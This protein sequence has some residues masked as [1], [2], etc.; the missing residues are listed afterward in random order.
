M[1]AVRIHAFGGP[2]TLKV[3]DLPKPEAQATEVLIRILGASVNPVDYK[4]RK[5]GYLSEDALPMT[6][7]RDVAGVVEAVGHGVDEFKEGDAVYAM[8]DRNHGGY[9]EYV[10]EPIAN[11]AK[12]PEKLDFIQAAAVPLAGLTAWQG[13]FDHG[14][15]KEGQTV[16]IH[17]AAGGVG[18]FAVQFA[19]ARGAKVIATCSGEDADFVKGLGA[20][21]V[22][23]YHKEK[24]EDRVG[25][26]DLVFDLVAG[27]TQER[28]FAVIRN[29]G[30]LV[31]T[32]KAPD[33]ARAAER[34]IRTA[35]YMAAPNGA[36][37]AEIGRLIDAGKVVPNIEGVFPLREAGAAEKEL[38]TAHVRGK[39][40]L[41]VGS[42]T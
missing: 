8:L 4:I 17:G 3:E 10:A 1:K 28:S 26:V 30:A 36:Q 18:H 40:V 13:L 24:F 16:L 11:V 7:G 20:S 32:L 34:R 35:H 2:E 12:K 33:K 15:L 37:L 27:E 25:D 22:I 6:L 5:G 9:A 14:G 31:S 21:E 38:E 23:D 41:A 39:L 42:K 29:G 19:V